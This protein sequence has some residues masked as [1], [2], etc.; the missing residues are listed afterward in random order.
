MDWLQD[1]RDGVQ[2]DWQGCRVAGRGC[3]VCEGCRV[4]GKGNMM[5]GMG[6]K[7]SEC[8]QGVEGSIHS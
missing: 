8:V 5:E 3:R 2:D 4:A 7:V 6:C 1:G